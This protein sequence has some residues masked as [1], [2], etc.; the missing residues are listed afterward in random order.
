MNFTIPLSGITMNIWIYNLVACYGYRDQLE[1]IKL[2][3][4]NLDPSIYITW[5]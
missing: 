3:L 5:F 4:T 1:K 2:L